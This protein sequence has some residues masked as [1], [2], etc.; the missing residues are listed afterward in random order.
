MILVKNVIQE[1]EID[2]FDHYR[3]KISSDMNFL[4]DLQAG[5][6]QKQIPWVNT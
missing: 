2:H 6:G 3:I 4:G 1:L 5:H